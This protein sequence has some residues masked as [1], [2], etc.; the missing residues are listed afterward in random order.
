LIERAAHISGVS[1]KFSDDLAADLNQASMF[2]YVSQSEGLGS[3]ALLA[4]AKGVP[5][6]ASRVGGLAELLDWEP[7]PGVAVPNDPQAIAQAM[8][9]VRDD[10][11][12]AATLIH[13]GLARVR[14]GFTLAHLIQGTIGSYE[15]ALAG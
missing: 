9:I 12:F 1:V 3:A 7:Q 4:M 2:V 8:K 13:G 14:S 5:V 11:A 15:R 10:P 6:I